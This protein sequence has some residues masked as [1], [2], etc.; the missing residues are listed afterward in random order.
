ML[1]FALFGLSDF[2]EVFT[3]AWL[4]PVYLLVLKAVCVITFLAAF[5]LYTKRKNA[6]KNA[7]QT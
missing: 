6:E 2:I 4:Q 3:R 1:S 7:I 5:V